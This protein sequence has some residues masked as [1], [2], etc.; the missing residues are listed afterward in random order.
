MR[1]WGKTLPGE[2]VE[3]PQR[4]WRTYV[5]QDLFNGIS[6]GHFDVADVMRLRRACLE[7]QKEGVKCITFP[8][9]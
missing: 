2:V 8:S 9:L 6:E 4:S 3:I 5:Y 1:T 7:A